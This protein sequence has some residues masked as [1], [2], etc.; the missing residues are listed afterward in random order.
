MNICIFAS[1]TGS[2]FNA[3]LK[4]VKSKKLNSKISLLISNNP[5]CGAV[6]IAK[7]NKTDIEIINRKKY[8]DLTDK[9]Y[10]GIFLKTLNEHNIDLI[11]LCGYMK[12]IEKDVLK[13][14]NNKII[15]IHPALLPSF[16][17]KG[18][19]GINVH[20]AVIAAGVKVSGIT[21]HYVNENYDE[22]KIIFQKCCEVSED[23]DEFT[24]QKR[25][26]KMEH[27]YYWQVVRTIED[28]GYGITKSGA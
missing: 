4:A 1:G 14:Y 15:N 21:I 3:I 19:F 22:G 23:D 7:E 16:G 25:V 9:Q 26:L 24:L 8:P 28:P 12:M 18:M 20:K 2:N 6:S 5:D 10:S 17:G 27:L 13:K 11:V